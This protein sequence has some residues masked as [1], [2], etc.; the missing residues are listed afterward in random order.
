MALRNGRRDELAAALARAEPWI[1]A[2][3]V[4]RARFEGLGEQ[5]VHGRELRFFS[6]QWGTTLLRTSLASYDAIVLGGDV[7]LAPP[8]APSVFLPTTGQVPMTCL[9]H[10]PAWDMPT[11]RSLS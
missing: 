9:I 4:G 2:S 1:P 6:S 5:V 10:F 8:P 7:I 11:F 3:L